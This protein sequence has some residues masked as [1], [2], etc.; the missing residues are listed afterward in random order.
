MDNSHN[1]DGTIITPNPIVVSCHDA[2]LEL[3]G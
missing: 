1:D 2:V 3:D